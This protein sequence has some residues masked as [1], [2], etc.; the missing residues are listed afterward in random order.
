LVAREEKPNKV[1]GLYKAD[2][3]L[4]LRSSELNPALDELYKGVLKDR[5]H[6]LLHVH[7]GE[8]K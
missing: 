3:D 7:Y 8:H 4:E 5:V 2:E 6:E 1:K